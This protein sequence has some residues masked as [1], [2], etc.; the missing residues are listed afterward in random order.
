MV[1]NL[2]FKNVP[3]D[4]PEP[5]VKELF[6]PYGDIKS[7]II[8]KNDFGQWGLVCYEDKTG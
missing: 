1:N 7:M 8:S 3:I 6:A 5:N 2:Y 4:M